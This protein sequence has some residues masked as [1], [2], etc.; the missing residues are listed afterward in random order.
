MGVSITKIIKRYGL[1]NS[2]FKKIREGKSL[3]DKW[4]KEHTIVQIKILLCFI[5]MIN[6]VDQMHEGLL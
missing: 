4:T 1:P 2:H 5:L 3:S 6:L